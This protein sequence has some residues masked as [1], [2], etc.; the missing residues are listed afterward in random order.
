L[1]FF[2]FLPVAIY[3]LEPKYLIQ[4]EKKKE[5]EKEGKGV[6]GRAA[7]NYKNNYIQEGFLEKK[8]KKK[9]PIS[10]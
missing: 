6:K 2:F 10:N 5:N 3:K 8:K 1:V 4:S 7:G 9:S